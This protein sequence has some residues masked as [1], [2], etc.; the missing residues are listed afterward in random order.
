MHEDWRSVSAARS[1]AVK[2]VNRGRGRVFQNI[3]KFK[4]IFKEI[5][6]FI[7]PSSKLKQKTVLSTS[8]QYLSIT[9]VAQISDA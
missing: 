8:R 4:Q 7:M 5:K 9:I 1:G 3:W 2:I 6:L